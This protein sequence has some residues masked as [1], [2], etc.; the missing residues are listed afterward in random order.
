ME[1]FACL[2]TSVKSNLDKAA[3]YLSD[4]RSAGIK[5]LTP[6]INRSVMNFDALSAD[7]VLLRLGC[8]AYGRWIAL[9]RGGCA[10]PRASPRPPGSVARR[11]G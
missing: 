1:Y 7:R 6:D 8:S 3:V 10:R 2:L 11:S 4:C 5:V 9:G